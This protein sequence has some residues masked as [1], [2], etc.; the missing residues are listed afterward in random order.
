[1][2]NFTESTPSCKERWKKTL[3][4]EPIYRACWK[5][6]PAEYWSS[7]PIRKHKSSIPRLGVFWPYRPIGCPAREIRYQRHF[8]SN[9]RKFQRIVS[10]QNRNGSLPKLQ[11]IVLSAFLCANVSEVIDGQGDSI[12]IIRDI[13]E[14]ERLASERA[15][16]SR[17]GGSRRRP[18]SRNPQSTRKHGTICRP[19]R[20]CHSANAGDSPVGHS[21][22]SWA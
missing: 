22:A 7:M 11:L 20:G 4:S 6:G 8:K 9:L 19:A 13:T 16:F 1:M 3:A 14:Q 18:G 15:Q 2:R 21:S 5:A 17:F 12:W 10:F